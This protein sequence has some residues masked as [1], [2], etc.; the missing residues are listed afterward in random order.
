MGNFRR[1]RRNP[2][3]AAVANAAAD[4]MQ[5]IL[6]ILSVIVYI[7]Y[8]DAQMS[9]VVLQNRVRVARAEKQMSQ[10]E[11]AVGAGVTRQT[12]GA[13]EKSQ[14]VPS[15]KLALLLARC[16]GKS[17]EEIFYLEEADNE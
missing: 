2:A 14:Y 7:G 10:E 3:T 16:L 17:V 11:L 15:T 1:S 13:I 8:G 5:C 4:F 6:Y 12:I 9:T